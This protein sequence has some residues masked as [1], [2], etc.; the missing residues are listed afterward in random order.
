MRRRQRP[1][2]RGQSLIIF[3]LA[4]F[5]LCG[6]TALA[7]DI[8]LFLTERREAQNAADAAALAGAQELPGSPAAAILAAREWAQ[9]NGF[10]HGSG[11]TAV[12]VTTP[13]QNNPGKVKVEISAKQPAYFA[14]VLGFEEFDVGASAAAEREAGPGIYAL[15]VLDKSKCAALNNTGSGNIQIQGGGIMVN[16]SCATGFRHAG[17]GNIETDVNHYYEEG[18]WVDQGSG[19]VTPQ[20]APR[21][22]RVEDPL[23]DLVQPVP[24]A[25][26]PGTEGTADNPKLTLINNSNDRTLYPGTYYGGLK[27]TGSG[28]VTLEPGLYIMA[29]G[30]MEFA[31]SGN[32]TGSN[33]TF[34]NTNDPAKPTGAGDYGRFKIVSSGNVDVSA[35]SAGPY[36]TLLFWQDRNNTLSFMHAGSGN[37]G[38]GIIYLPEAK[39]DESGSGNLG[40]VQ[41]IVKEYEKTG[42]GNLQITNGAY[43]GAGAILRLIE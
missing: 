35:P 17:N 38:P 2:E 41:I 22:S 39:L 40:A 10:E 1:G 29:G 42:S 43:V 37:I 14:R 5:T 34:Y 3:I 15:I 20:P 33:V 36:A 25:P 18:G 13:Y 21:S 4:F 28:N 11:G 16:S 12:N 32:I 9:N 24:G 26:A 6:V 31:A 19:N 7:V 27:L 23:E 8:G 30:G